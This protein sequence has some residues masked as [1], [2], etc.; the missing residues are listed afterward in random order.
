MRWQKRIPAYLDWALAHEARGYAWSAAE[1]KVERLLDYGEAGEVRLE[2]RLDRLDTGPDG[3]FVLDYK[4][5]SRAAL[6]KK[7]KQPGEDVQLPFYGLLTGA[8]GAA[9][10]GLDDDKVAELEL[11]GDLREAAG[12][13]GQRLQATLAALA[14]GAPLPAQGAPDTCQW[15]EMRGLCRREHR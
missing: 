6:Q 12:Q 15:C 3:T 14:A 8:A 13:E 9:L 2:G 7:L 5:Q 10:V 11:S 1:Q 4:A